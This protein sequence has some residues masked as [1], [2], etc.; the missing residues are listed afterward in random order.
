VQ[1]GDTLIGIAA[2]FGIPAQLLQT[3]NGIMDP[4][5]LQIGQELLIPPEDPDRSPALPTPTPVPVRVENTTV[6]EMSSGSFWVLG[7]IANSNTEPVERVIVEI[8]LLDADGLTVAQEEAAALLEVIQPGESAAF[9]ALFRSVPRPFSTYRVTVLSADILQH[10]GHLYLDFS[11]PAHAMREIAGD[12]VEVSGEVRN[13]GPHIAAPFVVVTAYNGGGKVVAVR[14]VFSSP[15]ILGPGEQGTFSAMLVS[16]G[17]PVAR[18]TVEA[19]G[20]WFGE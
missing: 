16:L 11:I 12:S 7:L 14:E 17:G 3:A 20:E 15:P 6:Y 2:Q 1:R 18:Y 5:R 19:Q 8:A 4:R 10:L 13:E 9:A